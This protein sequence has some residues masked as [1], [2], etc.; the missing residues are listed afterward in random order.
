VAIALFRPRGHAGDGSVDGAVWAPVAVVVV[1]SL[2]LAASGLRGADYPAHLLRGV[3]WE[4]SGLGV[5]NTYWYG[6]HPTPTYS[7]LAPPLTALV[8]PF[9]VVAA[10]SVV[11]TYAFSRITVGL[12]ATA[13]PNH[14]FAVAALVNVVVGRAPFALGLAAALLTLLNW[15]TGRYR[16]AVVFAVAT[17]L[18]SPVAAVFLAIAAASAAVDRW[19]EGRRRGATMA[20]LLAVSTTAPVLV[21]AS[22]YRSPG[23]FP[24]RGDQLVLSML[25]VVAV[26]VVTPYRSVRI[27]AW[28]TLVVSV[29]T[30]VVPNPLGGNFG[31]LSQLVAV[32]LLLLSVRHA[33]RRVSFP[34]VGLIAVTA[35]WSVQPGVVAALEWVGDESVE[36]DY[37]QPLIDEVLRRN[38]DG[39]PIGRLEIPFTENHWESFFVAPA[40]PYARGWERQVDLDRNDELYDDELSLSQY[41]SW[42][43]ENGVR[44]IAVA[45]VELDEGGRPE[46]ELVLRDG[47]ANDVS[48]LRQVWENDDWRLFEVRDYRPIVDGPAELVHQEVDRFIVRTPIAAR[49]SIRFE[50]TPDL[51]VDGAACAEPTSEGW[52]EAR[53]PAAGTYAFVVDPTAALPGGGS[54]DCG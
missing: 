19:R 52:V 1:V 25:A 50:Y 3:L 23:R 51:V 20:V 16:S 4:R 40:V 29:G 14:A 18:A 9:A 38:A 28:F 49:V 15:R 27:G 53:F 11:A 32:P 22:W 48:W 44:W 13:L 8:G 24:F 42:L 17:P 37:H 33:R 31:R 39:R 34:L 43:H 35:G 47:T 41:H 21:L 45:D 30:F 7:V 2:L 54:D 46:S 6:G 36:A 5:W 12:G 10:S 26:L